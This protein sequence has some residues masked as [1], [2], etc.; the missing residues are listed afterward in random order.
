MV[1]DFDDESTIAQEENEEDEDELEDL[2]KVIEFLFY[3]D[4][5]HNLKKV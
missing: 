1:H 3:D 2:A 5:N 4:Y